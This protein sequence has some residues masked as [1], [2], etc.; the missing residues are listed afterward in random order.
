MDLRPGDLLVAFT[1]GVT[2]AL[3]A[4]G[5]EFGEDRLKEVMR[6]AAGAPADAISKRLADTMREWIGNAE[7][8]DDLTFVV[9]AMNSAKVG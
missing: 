2:E 8:H 6:V 7:Q 5:E 1:D 9:V 4:E 3:N